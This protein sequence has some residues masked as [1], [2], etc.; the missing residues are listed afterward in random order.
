MNMRGQ[1]MP[2]W[3][4][5]SAGHLRTD[6][7]IAAWVEIGTGYARCV[8]EHFAKLMMAEAAEACRLQDHYLARR[9]SGEMSGSRSIVTWSSANEFEPLPAR[10][11]VCG[12]FQRTAFAHRARPRWPGTTVATLTRCGPRP[13]GGDYQEQV[14]RNERHKEARRVGSRVV[15]CPMMRED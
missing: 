7:Q 12:F 2:G 8:V 15:V 11:A 4:R 5:V 13:P 1:D 6:G 9:W 3:L 10:R 14:G